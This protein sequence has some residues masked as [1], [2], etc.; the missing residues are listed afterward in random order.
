MQVKRRKLSV[1]QQIEYM[2]INK[3]IK[4]NIMTESEAINFLTKNNY[5]FKLKSYAKNFDTYIKGSNKGKYINLEF[6]YLVELSIIDMYLR[7]FIIDASLDIEHFAKNKLMRDVSNNINEDGYE[8]VEILFKKYPRMKNNIKIKQNKY[9]FSK[10]LIDKYQ[11]NLAIW[12]IVEILSFGDFLKLY[13]LYYKKYDIKS[14]N[15]DLLW[16]VKCL[17]NAAA[18]NNC[19]LNSLKRKYSKE[20]ERNESIN[21]KI[22]KISNIN[23][24]ER[25]KKMSNPIVHDFVISLYAFKTI[26]TSEKIKKNKLNNLKDLLDNRMKSNKNYFKKNE[27]LISYYRFIK[28]IVDNFYEVE[29]NNK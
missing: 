21:L 15:N 9:S 23:K 18:H 11:D 4:F 2:K 17:R 27:M 28:K 10:D 25:I 12:N 6:A 26:V 19:L 8:I 13:K 1:I 7:K 5:Y 24:K 3:G 22:S 14:S 20:I 29:Y 16:S